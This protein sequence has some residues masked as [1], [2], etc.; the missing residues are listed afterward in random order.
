M[1]SLEQIEMYE[2][3][4]PLEEIRRLTRKTSEYKTGVREASFTFLDMLKRMDKG[5]VDLKEVM[6]RTNDMFYNGNAPGQPRSFGKR[7]YK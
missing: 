2:A 1:E 3:T 7:S 6:Q 4:E 5:E